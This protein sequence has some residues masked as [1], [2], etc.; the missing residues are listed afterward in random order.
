LIS[1]IYIGAYTAFS[2]LV[3]IAGVAMSRFGLHGT[4]LAYRAPVAVLAALVLV[5]LFL[6]RRAIGIPAPVLRMDK[7]IISSSTCRCA[8][9]Q[10]ESVHVLG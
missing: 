10:Y 1:A 5:S 8:P 4:R 3:E 6:R 7:P 2:L 9:P